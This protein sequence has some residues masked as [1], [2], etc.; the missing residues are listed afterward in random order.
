MSEVEKNKQFAE[1]LYIEWDKALANNDVDALL[2][3]YADDATLE[4]PLVMHV[5][6][7]KTEG[8]CHGQAELRELFEVL[9]KR[10]PEIRKYYRHDYFTRDQHLIWEYP[11]LS[12][13]GEQMDFVESIDFDDGGLITAQRVYWGWRGYKVMQDNAYHRN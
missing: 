11:R 9:A 7:H 8:V 2:A 3:L 12:L 1:R 4:S 10:K 6:Q 13:K 5:L